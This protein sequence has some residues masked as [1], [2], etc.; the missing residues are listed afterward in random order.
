MFDCYKALPRAFFFFAVCTMQRLDKSKVEAGRIWND[1]LI[2]I[3]VSKVVL[4]LCTT[5]PFMNPWVFF[6][7]LLA[8]TFAKIN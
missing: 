7:I 6:I 4:I 3:K 8:C 1:Q 5:P 2:V